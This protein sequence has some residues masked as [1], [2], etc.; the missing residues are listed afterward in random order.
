MMFDVIGDCQEGHVYVTSS[1]TAQ[2]ICTS[3]LDEVNQN[4]TAAQKELLFYHQKYG[5]ANM[6]WCQT[7]MRERRFKSGKGVVKEPPVIVT[8]NPRT[9]SCEAP[10]CA[11]CQLAKMKNQ[12]VDYRT[13]KPV[14]AHNDV[15]KKEHLLPGAA[16]SVDQYQTKVGGRLHGTYGREKKENQYNGG[17]IYVDHATGLIFVYNQVSLRAGE[18]LV[19]KALFEKYARWCGIEIKHIHGDNGVFASKEFRTDCEHKGQTFDFSGTGA[20]HQNSVAERAIQKASS[21]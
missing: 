16:I 11:A 15:I 3:V 19:G 12:G 6:Q 2:H 9:R 4:M 13:S 18:T 7:L 5:H 14:P 20:H 21:I 10:V 8:K 17:T 1:P